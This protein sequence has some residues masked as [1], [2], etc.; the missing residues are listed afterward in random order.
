MSERQPDVLIIGGGPAGSTAGTHLARRG[1]KVVLLEKSVHPRFHIGES[2]L[3][4]N[5]PVLDRLGVLDQV[6]KIGVPK[7]G[8][9][10]T[11]GDDPGDYATYHFKRALG[12]SGDHAFEVRREDFDALLFENCKTAGV[13]AREHHTVTDVEFNDVDRHCVTSVDPHG[14]VERWYPRFVVDA[15]GRDALV[16]SKQRNKVRNGR[17]AT[18]ALFAHFEGVARRAGSDA[19]NISVYWFEYGWIW[20]IPLQDNVMSVGAV[21]RPGYLKTRRGSN[22]EFLMETLAKCPGALPRM[23]GSKRLSPVRAAGNYSYRSRRLAGDGYMLLGDAYAFVDPVFSSGVYLAMYG[24]ERAVTPI[25]TWLGGDKRRF[26]QQVRRYE[27]EMGRGLSTYSWF[28]YR[29]TSPA[30]RNLFRNP[31]N[32]LQVEDAVV[33]VLAGDVFGNAKIPAP[34]DSVS[35]DLRRKLVTDP[36]R[37]MACTSPPPERRAN[38]RQFRD[39]MKPLHVSYEPLDNASAE[40]H[41]VFF[42]FLFGVGDSDDAIDFETG[43]PQI[44]GSPVAETWRCQG[45]PQRTCSGRVSAVSCGG[46]MMASTYIDAHPL[47]AN[48]FEAYQRLLE[49]ID[50]QGFHDIV[51]IWNMVPDINGGDGDQENYKQFCLG[52]AEAFDAANLAQCPPPAATAVGLA[53]DQPLRVFILTALQAPRLLENPRQ[54]SAFSY[55]RVYGPRSPSFSR[56][57]LLDTQGRRQMFLSGTAAIVGHESQHAGD[58]SRQVH[59]LLENIRA[60]IRN[61]D[62]ADASATLRVYVRDM[63]LAQTVREHMASLTNQPERMVILAADICRQELLVEV[64]GVI[65]CARPGIAVQQR[66]PVSR[67]S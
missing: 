62:L 27:R 13:D 17:H 32:V 1:H 19:G 26:R 10:F 15:S 60:L 58:D 57:S 40:K 28:I 56:A 59:E 7:M 65:E 48:T 53:S 38:G 6:R 24:A 33:S 14:S 35:H 63:E 8:A 29:F 21:C 49:F 12:T 11:H 5:L 30:M 61:A 44:Y 64:D 16:A 67:A 25:D 45:T 50:A 41:G 39:N 54:V 47:R 42:R 52:R 2:L 18:A 37:I 3:P 46:Y 51:R 4:M 34:T 55:P 36:G 66:T 23:R 31:R 43:L 20:M 9:D 22:E